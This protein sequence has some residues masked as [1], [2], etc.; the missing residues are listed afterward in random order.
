MG[1]IVRA[2][3]GP[4]GRKKRAGGGGVVKLVG[5]GYPCWLGK[6]GRG[7]CRSGEG[8]EHEKLAGT[9]KLPEIRENK[10]IWVR[11]WREPKTRKRQ[12]GKVLAKRET[13]GQSM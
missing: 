8:Q 7:L 13:T 12:R 10:K 9:L 3:M 2:E 6:T 5:A 11:V 1:N 4:L